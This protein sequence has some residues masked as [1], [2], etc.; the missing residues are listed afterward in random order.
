MQDYAL[1][2]TLG[3]SREDPLFEPIFSFADFPKEAAWR[4]ATRRR[5]LE[6]A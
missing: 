4:E 2:Q 3:I 1:L 5:L 6:R